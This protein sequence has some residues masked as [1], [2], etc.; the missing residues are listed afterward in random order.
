[1][2]VAAVA[3]VQAGWSHQGLDH[4]YCP[5]YNDGARMD[6]ARM[7]ATRMHMDLGVRVEAEVTVL[8]VHSS[9]EDYAMGHQ[10]WNLGRN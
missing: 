9:P 6:A 7:D 1:M 5:T 3:V 4:S 10:K 8:P 2:V